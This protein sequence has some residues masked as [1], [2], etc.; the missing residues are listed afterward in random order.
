MASIFEQLM[1][2]NREISMSEVVKESSNL[3]RIPTNK[4][5][6]ESLEVLEEKSVE[7]TDNLFKLPT[8]DSLDSDE[9]KDIVVIVDPEL[10][11]EDSTKDVDMEKAAQE[12]INQKLYK[13]PVCGGNYVCRGNCEADEE[14]NPTECPICGDDSVQ[15]EVGVI[16][17]SEDVKPED[18]VNADS[19]DN[20][21]E[22]EVEEKE[23]TEEE[24]S[25]EEKGEEEEKVEEKK[26]DE[27]EVIEDSLN[28]ESD[29][30]EPVN[31]SVTE[32]V[33]PDSQKPTVET[34]A[35]LA[36]SL[37][38]RDRFN[39]T[40]DDLDVEARKY[41]LKIVTGDDNKHTITTIKA[42]QEKAQEQAQE[43]PKAESVKTENKTEHG[44]DC[45]CE[46]CKKARLSKVKES[47]LDIDE[48]CLESLM[49]D[50]LDEN[51]KGAVSCE[52]TSAKFTKDGQLA[53]EYVLYKGN[54]A[55]EE[56]RMV[57]EKRL[58]KSTR[59]IDESCT[60][61][62]SS[63]SPAFTFEFVKDGSKI[64]PTSL[65]YNFIK[66]IN[67]SV[68]AIR[69]NCTLTESAYRSFPE[70]EG[71]SFRTYLKNAEDLVAGDWVL[72]A[73]TSDG[74]KRPEK[75]KDINIWYDSKGV[76][77]VYELTPAHIYDFAKVQYGDGNKVEVFNDYPFRGVESFEELV[78]DYNDIG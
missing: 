27:E 40:V 41:G 59:F 52:F 71:H 2:Q 70:I 63:K 78:D 19:E 58:S 48:E 1:A 73:R 50:F 38:E 66:Q 57:S 8:Q 29:A 18:E 17:S 12:L 55:I 13:C 43:A 51:Y 36:M 5:K 23:E 6:L 21:E 25:E 26:E 37:A 74:E 16:A 42:A 54:K 53:L 24:T 65:T 7:E 34:V 61:A 68:Y 30:S 75:I 4:I 15:I 47:K 45:N 14:G 64:V 44:K 28:R 46:D 9:V 10:P 60:F 3:L 22:K 11:A 35:K 31:E 20:E 49:N 72:F 77:G 39:K 67:E 62:E 56:G 69:G 32:D 76:P 33:I